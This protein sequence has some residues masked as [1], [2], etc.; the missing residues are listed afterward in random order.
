MNWNLPHRQPNRHKITNWIKKNKT[1]CIQQNSDA[2]NR[3]RTHF[4]PNLFLYRCTQTTLR[5]SSWTGFAWFQCSFIAYSKT[6]RTLFFLLLACVWTNPTED[7]QWKRKVQVQSVVY[8]KWSYSCTRHSN[9]MTFNS[10]EH[11]FK[12]QWQFA[13]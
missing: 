5:S 2:H 7:R 9:E 11:C 6:I 12:W 1:S 10:H 3:N 4:N 8:L 13:E